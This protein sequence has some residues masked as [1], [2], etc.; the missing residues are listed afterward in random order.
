MAVDDQRVYFTAANFDQAAFTLEPEGSAAIY[1]SGFGSAGLVDGE[2]VWEIQAPGNSL[3]LAPP[4]VVGD[5]VLVCTSYPINVTGPAEVHGE[6]LALDKYTG[7]TLL[8]M[9]LDNVGYGGIA[10]QNEYV[11]FGA[12]YNGATTP[13]S[14]YVLKGGM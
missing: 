3:S 8:D 7:R 11:L 1:N 12:G 14:F 13:A 4:T 10:V 6:L 5:V 2:L 9:A